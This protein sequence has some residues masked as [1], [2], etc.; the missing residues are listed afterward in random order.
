MGSILVS[1]DLNELIQD[2]LTLFDESDG[3]GKIALT[4]LSKVLEVSAA[5]L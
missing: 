2:Q 3:I 4:A 5:K 1:P